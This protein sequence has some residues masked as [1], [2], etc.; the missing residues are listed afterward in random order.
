[1]P[2]FTGMLSFLS[3][4]FL[5][6]HIL[7]SKKQ[8][9][10]MYSRLIVGLSSADMFSS[11]F[12]FFLS[13]WPMPSGTWLAYGAS[14][15]EHTCEMQGFFFQL[16]LCAATLYQAS[17]VSFYFLTISRGWSK[18]NLKRYELLFHALPCSVALGTAVAGLFLQLYNA[19][20][21][22]NVCW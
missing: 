22:G 1:M 4:G 12:G 17:L 3:S 20:P 15:N 21:R 14:G 11:F 13:T 7:R 18:S 2:A 8:R 16:G 19:M 6:Q 9:H 5:V 10:S